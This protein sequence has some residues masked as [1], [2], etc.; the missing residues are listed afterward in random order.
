[1][2]RIIATGVLALAVAA[3]G[4]GAASTAEA[5]KRVAILQLTG[6]T[7]LKLRGTGFLAGE[8]VRVR[9]LAGSSGKRKIVYATRGGSFVVAFPTVPFDRCNGLVAEAVGARG[10]QARLKFPQLLCPP[11]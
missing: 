5:S 1:V 9:V 2:T 11:N 7:P 3:I 4:G 6:E 10:S 8:R